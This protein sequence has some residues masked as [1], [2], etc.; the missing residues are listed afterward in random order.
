MGALDSGEVG[1]I[2]SGGVAD[3]LCAA[4]IVVNGLET[5]T[6]VGVKEGPSLCVVCVVRTVADTVDEVSLVETAGVVSRGDEDELPG[7][8]VSRRVGVGRKDAKPDDIFVGGDGVADNGRTID[9]VVPLS[10]VVFGQSL[11]EMQ[12]DGGGFVAGD[13]SAES[14]G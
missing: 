1:D 10:T 3:E 13:D 6:T 8:L 11:A 4:G 12:E 14:R 5:D 9:T 7:E 2:G